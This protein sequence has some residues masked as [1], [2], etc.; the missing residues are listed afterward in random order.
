[1]L[2]TLMRKTRSGWRYFCD[3][4]KYMFGVSTKPQ[5][6]AEEHSRPAEDD[7]VAQAATLTGASLVIAN[8]HARTA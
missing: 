8:G 5:A 1:M 6:P 3:K 4:L 7:H 2:K